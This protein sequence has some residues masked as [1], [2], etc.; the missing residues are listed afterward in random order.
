MAVVIVLTKRSTSTGS[1]VV[2]HTSEQPQSNRMTE[3]FVKS[4][5]TSLGRQ[6][7]TSMGSATAI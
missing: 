6:A 4:V 3:A 7:E 1:L 5:V 2:I